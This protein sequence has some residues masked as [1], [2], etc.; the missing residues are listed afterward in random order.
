[1]LR[2]LNF[3][4]HEKEI[5]EGSYFDENVIRSHLNIMNGGTL[6]L[7]DECSCGLRGALPF[8]RLF[9]I[10]TT[11]ALN[12]QFSSSWEIRSHALFL[13]SAVLFVHWVLWELLSLR[14]ICRRTDIVELDRT[15]Q[16]SEA[17]KV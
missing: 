15:A 2:N 10:I 14:G 17:E 12:R 11:A 1:M 4:Q 7:L 3:C 5:H 6:Q 16:K 9:Q 13:A 8:M